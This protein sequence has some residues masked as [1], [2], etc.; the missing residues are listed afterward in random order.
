M[1]KV[2]H[3]HHFPL[4]GSNWSPK[5]LESIYPSVLIINAHFVLGADTHL[6]CYAAVVEMTGKEGVKVV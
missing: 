4:L 2:R 5:N 3:G 6:Y 1:L